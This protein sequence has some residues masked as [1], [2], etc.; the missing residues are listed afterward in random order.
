MALISPSC[1]LRMSAG[2]ALVLSLFFS[3]SLSMSRSLACE[4]AFSLARSAALWLLVSLMMF[5]RN[6]LFGFGAFAGLHP[7]QLESAFAVKARNPRFL[8]SACDGG[9]YRLDFGASMPMAEY[10]SEKSRASFATSSAR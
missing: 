6:R 3:S 10:F 2:P 4:S 8:G 9:T 1:L 7:R 5:W